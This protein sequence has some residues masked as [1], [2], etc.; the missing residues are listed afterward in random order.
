MNTL[1][2]SENIFRE[3]IANSTTY[4]TLS[5]DALHKTVQDRTRIVKLKFYNSCKFIKDIQNKQYV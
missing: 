3:T 4:T 1:N 5:T 2:D